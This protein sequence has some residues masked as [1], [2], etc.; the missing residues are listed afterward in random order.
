ML[1]RFEGLD[2]DTKKV[3]YTFL[4]DKTKDKN[5]LH[6]R[7][8]YLFIC[9]RALPKTVQAGERAHR[10]RG[11]FS[12]T[13]HHGHAQMI[14]LVENYSMRKVRFVVPNLDAYTES[15]QTTTGIISDCPLI[16]L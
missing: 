3:A 1:P 9:L 11:K 2:G 14:I 5:F 6:V 7:A 16:A 12:I 10:S 15:P 13:A 4:Y 8:E